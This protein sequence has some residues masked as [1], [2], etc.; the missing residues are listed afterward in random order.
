LDTDV[1]SDEELFAKIREGQDVLSV[2]VDVIARQYADLL[3][4]FCGRILVT[5]TRQR[6]EDV[7]QEIFVAVYRN[8]QRYDMKRG[9]EGIKP[10][11]HGIARNKCID[12]LKKK[13]HREVAVPDITELEPSNPGVQKKEE[14]DIELIL[15]KR[16]FVNLSPQER[17][18]IATDLMGWFS[19]KEMA[20]MFG[21][22]NP[23]SY[24]KRMYNIRQKIKKDVGEKSDGPSK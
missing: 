6:L 13:A 2:I 19:R 21:Y 12:E 5:Y 23:E 22:D 17:L 11:L 18:M 9:H 16:A 4:E 14:H 15:M 20:S 3:L 8:I 24:D 1:D 7:V 10:W